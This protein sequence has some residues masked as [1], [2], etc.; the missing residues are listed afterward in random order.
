MSGKGIARWI[1]AV[2]EA[3]KWDSTLTNVLNQYVWPYWMKLSTVLC[4]LKIPRSSL[5][6]QLH[7]QRGSIWLNSISKSREKQ[8]VASM[9]QV[10]VAAKKSTEQPQQKSRPPRKNMKNRQG[11]RHDKYYTSPYR[12][13]TFATPIREKRRYYKI[14]PKIK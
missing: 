2:T 10:P 8:I 12:I 1:S 6:R 11:I 4:R 14:E 3:V 9:P 13:T 5:C 7:Q